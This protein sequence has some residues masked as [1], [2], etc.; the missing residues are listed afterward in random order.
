MFT[1]ESVQRYEQQ[2]LEEV[3]LVYCLGAT[4]YQCSNGS[5]VIYNNV[6][7][8]NMNKITQKTPSP[9]ISHFFPINNLCVAQ[10]NKSEVFD[11]Y[12]KNLIDNKVGTKGS[13]PRKDVVTKTIFRRARKFFVLKFKQFHDYT[14]LRHKN[15]CKLL[16]NIVEF[17][18]IYHPDCNTESM[19]VLV[20]AFLDPKS[21]YIAKTPE[22]S[23]I[24]NLGYNLVYKFSRITIEELFTFPEFSILISEFVKCENT[25]NQLMDGTDNEAARESYT[26]EIDLMRNI[27]MNPNSMAS[28]LLIS[29]L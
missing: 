9:L 12:S 8:S 23:R 6:E 10:W 16:E 7:L 2:F 25:I 4:N 29:L 14:K 28:K 22:T 26:K 19:R 5:E 18:K 11:E 1:E 13:C 3:S 17:I 15:N 27:C 24:R 21:K 20:L